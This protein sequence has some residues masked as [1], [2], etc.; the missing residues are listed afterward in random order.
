MIDICMIICH[1]ECMNHTATDHDQ[2]PKELHY[3]VNCWICADEAIKE[4]I[5]RLEREIEAL[6]SAFLYEGV[7]PTQK[8]VE[9]LEKV[10]NSIK[11][12]S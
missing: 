7:T 4:E 10:N 1:Y 6:K 12:I 9:Q 3:S 8:M 5:N 2:L 11:G